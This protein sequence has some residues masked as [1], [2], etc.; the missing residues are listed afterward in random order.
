MLLVVV[1]MEAHMMSGTVVVLRRGVPVQM[2]A[3]DHH[4]GTRFT[5]T[6]HLKDVN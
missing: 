3:I 4:P 5:V 2:V 1:P 6:V